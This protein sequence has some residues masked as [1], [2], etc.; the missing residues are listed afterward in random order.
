MFPF[1]RAGKSGTWISDRLPH[2]ERAIDDLCVIK[3]MKTDQF[4]HAP[5]QLLVH[6]GD[7]RTGHA[8]LG[9]WVTYGLG[10][11]NQYMPGFI[12]LIS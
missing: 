9:S 5:A 3:S 1:H 7:P 12:V 8:S 10:S 4:N 2:L 11:E 6:T